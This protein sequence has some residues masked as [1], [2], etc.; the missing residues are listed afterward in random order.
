MLAAPRA[1]PRHCIVARCIGAR[2]EDWGPVMEC[3]DLF[4]GAGGA[5]MGYRQPGLDVTGV[6]TFG[7]SL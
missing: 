2:P 3:L 7:E 6:V 1:P 4:S 5:A